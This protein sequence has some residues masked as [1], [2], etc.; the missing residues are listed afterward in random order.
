M[1]VV[2][3]VPIRL[4]SKRVIGKNLR[5]LGG[6]PLL[7]Y[8]F[9]KLVAVKEIDEVYAYCSSEAIIPFLP[10][11]VIFLKRN[12]ALDDDLTLGKDIYDAFCKSVDADVYILAHTTS[13]FIK[14]ESIQNALKAVL[15]EGYDSSF[16]AQQFK[17]FSWYKG[18]PLN[19]Q[20]DFVPRTQDLE[21]VY[22]ETSAFFIFRKE[23]WNNKQQRIGDNPYLQIVDQI[24]GIDIDNPED[25]IIAEKF[26]HSLTDIC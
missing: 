10:K 24:E 13:P 23:V 17:T 26:I 22:I 5:E 2:A 12:L 11:N 4:N 8:I 1:K 21:P 20:L 25:F 16:S 6:K 14:E 3:F 18:K 19:Y 7:S 9:N 15:I